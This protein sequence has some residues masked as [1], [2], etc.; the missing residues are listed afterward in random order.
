MTAAMDAVSPPKDSPLAR[1]A[2]RTR[3]ETLFD[4]IPLPANLKSAFY[5]ICRNANLHTGQCFRLSYQNIADKLDVKRRTAINWVADLEGL[6]WIDIQLRWPIEQRDP[7]HPRNYLNLITIQVPPAFLPLVSN[8][9]AEPEED[10]ARPPDGAASEEDAATDIGA[11]PGAPSIA[12]SPARSSRSSSMPVTS[13]SSVPPPSDVPEGQDGGAEEDAAGPAQADEV[14]EEDEATEL[15]A[16]LE[17]FAALCAA[18]S[19]PAL[20]S[21]SAPTSSASSSASPGPPGDCG[22][23][24]RDA[25]ALNDEPMARSVAPPDAPLLPSAPATPTPQEG[26]I[27]AIFARHV[28][29]P[30][31]PLLPGAAATSSSSAPRPLTSPCALP[32]AP[33]E[34]AISEILARHADVL[35]DLPD[36]FSARVWRAARRNRLSLVKALIGIEDAADK[37]NGRRGDKLADF[38]IGCIKNVPDGKVPSPEAKAAARRAEEA[39]DVMKQATCT[40]ASPPAALETPR[41]RYAGRPP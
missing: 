20:S 26:A 7:A 33:Q 27:G 23:L 37:S 39:L 22:V 16:A 40:P 15:A 4:S 25:G 11:A 3:V 14:P 38:M 2:L 1:A 12:S 36:D 17:E 41:I 19:E 10:G 6:G 13:S 35:P 18:A 5:T 8:S 32:A 34:G 31:A 24:V 9:L 29:P 28:A 30:G 21:S